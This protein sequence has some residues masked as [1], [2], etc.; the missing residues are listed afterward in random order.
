MSHEPPD[1]FLDDLREQIDMYSSR[2]EELK[3]VLR[4]VYD[5]YLHLWLGY[6]LYYRD[7]NKQLWDE[8]EKVL[9][10]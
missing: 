6:D 9:N 1:P 8:V 4:K 3:N 10:K 5:A 7:M 2:A